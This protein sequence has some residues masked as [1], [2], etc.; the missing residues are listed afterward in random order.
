MSELDVSCQCF[1]DTVL[2]GWAP[3][4][5]GGQLRKTY[6]REGG[7]DTNLVSRAASSTR[8][9][10][11]SNSCRFLYLSPL[12]PEPERMEGTTRERERR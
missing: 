7:N 6:T 12:S 10:S 1:V 11:S 5:R 9:M 8:S 3:C 4:V 2:T